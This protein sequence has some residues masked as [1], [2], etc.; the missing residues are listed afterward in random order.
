MKRIKLLG[1]AILLFRFTTSNL[2]Y[3]Y[4]NSKL[5][6]EELFIKSSYAS[7]H[8]DHQKAVD[9]LKE[10]LLID[11][12]NI[13]LNEKYST[14]LI[15][16]GEL[17]EAKV[18]L[19]KEYKTNNSVKNLVGI[20]LA[21]IYMA[22]DSPN[23]A[24]KIYRQMITFN[25]EINDACILLAKSIVS[26]RA[27]LKNVKNFTKC[28][29]KILGDNYYS[30]LRGQIEFKL[31]HSKKA[32]GFYQNSLKID[33]SFAP[34]V[35]GMGVLYEKL[36]NMKMAIKTYSDYLNED[37]NNTNSVVLSNLVEDLVQT[38]DISSAV[39]VAEK[40]NAIE[41]NN[42]NLKAQLGILYTKLGEY[43]R[44]LA[45]FKEVLTVVPDSNKILF[46]L[47][48]VNQEL[49]HNE[50]ALDFYRKV[51]SDSIFYKNAEEKIKEITEGKYIS[52]ITKMDIQNFELKKS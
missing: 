40:L 21:A 15:Q 37:Q 28:D 35:I 13:Y 18:I 46:F 36:Q 52:K 29:R 50:Y 24:L 10:A 42:F 23:K 9:L 26:N 17:D 25:H 12:T 39:V 47:G 27:S 14:E 22:S 49:N 3:S 1:L 4:E 38:N 51:T 5:L 7:N 34:S 44:A 20:N 31:G 48:V 43:N 33:Q 32:L 6:A 16:I 2:A 19:E 41:K 45:Y 11:P 8:G 30:Y